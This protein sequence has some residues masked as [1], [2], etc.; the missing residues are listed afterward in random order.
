MAAAS[1]RGWISKPFAARVGAWSPAARASRIG[2][3]CFATTRPSMGESLPSASRRVRSAPVRYS[4]EG[5]DASRKLS[6]AVAAITVMGTS[7]GFG[8]TDSG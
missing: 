6:S 1:G 3:R 2:T 7:P 4:D 8:G 5:T